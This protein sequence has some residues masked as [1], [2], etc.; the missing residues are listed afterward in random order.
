M[1]KEQYAKQINAVTSY[2][3]NHLDENLELKRMAEI[4]NLSVFHFH[5]IARA[6]LNEPFG[7][8]VTRLRVEAAASQLRY[9]NQTISEIAYAV[10]FE[11]PSG[12]SKRFK[13]YY[14]ITPSQYRENIELHIIGSYKK[15]TMGNVQPIEISTLEDQ[16]IA[17]IRLTG[18]YAELDY[19]GAWKRLWGF[20]N[21][22]SLS[23]EKSKSIGICYDDPQVTQSDKCRYDVAVT[24][25]GAFEAVGE[26]GKGKIAGGTFAVFEHKG[27]YE[28]LD[29]VYGGIYGKWL[30][31]SGRE[32]RN[33][34]TIDFFLNSPR[35]TNPKDLVTHIYLPVK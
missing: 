22:Q 24:I 17:Y 12:L 29:E 26:I 9:T 18:N 33:A 21:E 3:D 15:E 7:E 34:P 31:E 19:S 20:L 30:F 13:K 14:N 10:G 2:V 25:D 35:D 1:K 32:L 28:K 16:T 23:G 6:I 8:Y 27:P 11:T 5:R 4:A